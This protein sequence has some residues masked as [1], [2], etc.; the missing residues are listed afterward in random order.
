MT[1]YG[2]DEL[3]FFKAM[4]DQAAD[5][6]IVLAS[7]L[8]IVYMNQTAKDWFGELNPG[9]SAMCGHLLSCQTAEGMSM[10]NSEQ[11]FGC[12]VFGQHRSL[13]AE[14][15]QVTQKNGTVIPVNVSYSYIPLP[16]GKSYTLMALRDI[17][18]QKRWEEEKQANES[19]R[20]TLEERERIARDLHDT[21]AQDLAY[22]T[23]QLKR[24]RKAVVQQS[25]PQDRLEGELSSL[26][27][28][29]DHCMQELRNALYDLSFDLE[30][31]FMH[32]VKD[33]ANTLEL[34]SNIRT[35]LVIQDSG[36]PWPERIEVQLARIVKEVLTNIRKHAC[37]SQVQI[38]ILRKVSE[39]QI[40]IADDGTG[41]E[42]NGQELEG[43]YGLKSIKER[44][45][46][47]GGQAVVDSEPGKGTVWRF[48]IPVPNDVHSSLTP[49]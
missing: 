31:D 9:E 20:M 24:V 36:G 32:F 12:Q 35:K 48:F 13:S 38:E 37:A 16:S 45:R 23:F 7:D 49:V 30:S 11:C 33:C 47:L 29:M 41:F 5:G 46:L 3:I 25:L 4:F 6:Y 19:L 15:M 17:T 28:V 44:C 2:E 39:I 27:E 10:V 40:S 34:R 18:A 14:Q 8:T 22:A 1:K 43:R 42:T 21:V 26:T